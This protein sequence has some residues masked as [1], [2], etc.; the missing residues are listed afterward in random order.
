MKVISNSADIKRGSEISIIRPYEILQK[1]PCTTDQEIFVCK[2][3]LSTVEM[4]G[5][6][7]DYALTTHKKVQNF[8]IICKHTFKYCQ[9]HAWEL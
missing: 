9:T 3:I 4:S 5:N 8:Y 1:Y 7:A 2:V 6:V